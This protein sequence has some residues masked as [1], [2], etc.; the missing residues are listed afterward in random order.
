MAHENWQQ[1]KEIFVDALLQ[2]P[3]E[4]QNFLDDVCGDDKNLRREVES[5]LSSLDGAGE[6]YGNASCRRYG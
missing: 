6:F 1:V 3:E 2:K 5:L 4:R